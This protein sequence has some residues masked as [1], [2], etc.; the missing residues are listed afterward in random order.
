MSS[1]R[2]TCLRSALTL[3]ELSGQQRPHLRRAGGERL[4]PGRHVPEIRLAR[5]TS[6]TSPSGRSSPRD[7]VFWLSTHRR[8]SDHRRVLPLPVVERHVA[9]EIR[10]PPRISSDP[11][12]VRRPCIPRRRPTAQQVPGHAVRLH[13]ER[14]RLPDRVREMIGQILLADGD[15]AILR[16]CQF[17]PLFRDRALVMGGLFEGQR[18]GADRIGIVPRGQAQHG[19]RTSPP[20]RYT[21]TGTSARRRMRTASSSSWRNSAACSASSA[22]KRRGRPAGSRSP[23]TR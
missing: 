3:H 5:G 1:R 2:R 4:D 20:L 13:A 17:R 12:P 6:P 22:P 14:F 16:A 10:V 19:A 15:R 7:A 8:L 18:E 23:G 21:P 11:S 9:P